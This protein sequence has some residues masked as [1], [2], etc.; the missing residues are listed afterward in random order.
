[1]IYSWNHT[2]VCR[3]DW[4]MND[5]WHQQAK[6]NRRNVHTWVHAN[7]ADVSMEERMSVS[8]DAGRFKAYGLEKHFGFAKTICIWLCV[9]ARAVYLREGKKIAVHSACASLY[10]RAHIPTLCNTWACCVEERRF[11]CSILF[12]QLCIF[13]YNFTANA[14]VFAKS[15]R[16][17]LFFSPWFFDS[18]WRTTASSKQFLLL[19][20]RARKQ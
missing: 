8:I 3:I 4:L 9:C 14:V 5:W 12:V 18:F 10:L 19:I 15:D 6:R 20:L 13:V 2:V 1:M 7:T 11:F 16:P 17:I